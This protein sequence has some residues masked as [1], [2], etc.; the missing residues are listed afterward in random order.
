MNPRPKDDPEYVATFDEEIAAVQAASLEEARRFWEELYGADGLTMSVVG[1]FDPDEVRSI[2]EELFADWKAKKPY[3]RFARPY[4]DVAAEHRAIETPDKANAMMMAGLNLP[5]RDDSPDYPAMVLGTYMLGG[6]FLNSR[7]ATRIRQKEGLSYGVGAGFFAHPIDERGRLTAYA[8]FAPQNAEKLEQA[9]REEIQKVL[10]EGFTAEEVKAAKEG[11]LQSREV[12][13][14]Q[15]MSLAN[16]LSASL[17]YD[18]TLAFDGELEHKVGDLTPEEIASAMRKYIDPQ[19]ITVIMA[20]DFAT[21]K[22]STD[23]T[24]DSGG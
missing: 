2:A 18:R 7:L 17:F 24:Q 10:D 22:E 1:D 4:Q 5:I 16:M 9:F 6:G 23:G 3:V 21:A 20:G 12:S 13:R 8:I 19:K 15:D 14:A 11:W